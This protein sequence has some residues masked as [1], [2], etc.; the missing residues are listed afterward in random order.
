MGV[1]DGIV[2]VC[3]FCVGVLHVHVGAVLD[4]C[5]YAKIVT[6]IAVACGVSWWVEMH[7]LSCFLSEL[8]LF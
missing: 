6:V 3:V 5:A 2:G 8:W 7:G 1:L 4:Q